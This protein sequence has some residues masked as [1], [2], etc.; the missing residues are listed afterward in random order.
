MRVM[1]KRKRQYQTGRRVTGFTLVELVIAIGILAFALISILQVFVSCSALA[2]TARNKSLAIDEA[3][4]LIERIRN[5]DFD[6]VISDFV[7]S[8]GGSCPCRD[9]ED[10]DS[11][12]LID[13]GSGGDNGCLV[14][15]DPED[16]TVPIA[17][18]SY[19]TEEEFEC[20]D[21]R[22]N[23]GNG[24]MDY[25]GDPGCSSGADD[26]EGDLPN[27]S[28]GACAGTFALSQLTGSGTI[29]IDANYGVGNGSDYEIRIYDVRVTVSWINRFSPGGS[30]TL[31]TMV[32]RR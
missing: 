7:L 24:L 11:D 27:V 4:G 14:I 20:A 25:P 12:A 16:T 19:D 32:S 10:N 31:R 8:G 17:D 15:A 21:G 9:S 2:E 29:S 30:V 13:F 18:T 6:E 22:D 5:H 3:Q 1:G 23:D 28:L 26:E